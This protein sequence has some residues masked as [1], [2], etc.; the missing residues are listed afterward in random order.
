MFDDRSLIQAEHLAALRPMLRHPA[1]YIQRLVEHLDFLPS[2]GQRWHRDLQILLPEVAG[3]SRLD[4]HWY[5]VSLGQFVRRRLPDFTVTD[6]SGRTVNLLTRVQHG[7]CLAELTIDRFLYD[8][9]RDQLSQITD[10]DHELMKAYAKVYLPT[11]EMFTSVREDLAPVVEK[12][13]AELLGLLGEDDDPARQ[14][15]E[16]FMEKITGVLGVTQ[17]LCWVRGRPGMAVRLTATYTMPD[18]ML[19]PGP[20]ATDGSEQNWFKRLRMRNRK[21]RSRVYARLGVVPMRSTF[22]TPANDHA[23]SYYFSLEPPPESTIT[24]LDWGLNNTL[25]GDGQEWVCAHD[26]VHV[27]NGG[28]LRAPGAPPRQR[29]TIPDSR[30]YAFF[31]LDPADHKQVMFSALLNV[32]FVWLAEAGRL[33]SEIEGAMGPWL[34]LAPAVLLAY[35]AQQRQHYFARDTRWARVVLWGYLVLN[36]GFLVSISFDIVTSGSLAAR[37]GLG[38]DAVSIV[39]AS[40]SIVVFWLFAFLGWPYET[41]VNWRFKRERRKASTETSVQSYARVARW[42]GD[43][44]AVMIAFSLAVMAAVLMLGWGPNLPKTESAETSKPARKAQKT[45]GKREKPPGPPAGKADEEGSAPA[46]N[47]A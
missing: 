14:R 11:F 26:S 12:S 17:Y 45:E 20:G 42:Y 23:A 1:R 27:H 18:P 22:R 33:H 7:H 40:A 34:A 19:L 35:T 30:I 13:F 31:R 5:V 46:K 28:G 9:E 24:Y 21:W 37:G 4:D 43:V 32:V 39:M 3:F 44:A 29:T 2:G 10:P 15:A 36:I 25:E 6:C 8:H 47:G 41:V 16:L 38:D